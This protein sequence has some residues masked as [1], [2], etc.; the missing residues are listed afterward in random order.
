MTNHYSET[1][2]V[3]RRRF[4]LHGS[5]G[6]IRMAVTLPGRHG[7]ALE[8]AHVDSKKDAL[9]LCTLEA[10]QL[11]QQLIRV[12]FGGL[13]ADCYYVVMELHE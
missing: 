3:K 4:V 1:E 13:V 8:L 6:F 11:L 9:Q 2:P 12:H 10:A 7:G 5:K